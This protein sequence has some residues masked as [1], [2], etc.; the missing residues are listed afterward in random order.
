MDISNFM[1]K[2]TSANRG[3]AGVSPAQQTQSA[4]SA[5]KASGLTQST[6]RVKA[7]ATI[8]AVALVVA[9]LS[10]LFGVVMRSQAQIE[11]KNATEGAQAVLVGLSDIKAG[12]TLTEEN[13]TIVEVPAAYRSSNVLLGSD[14]SSVLGKTA[15]V[16]VSKGAQLSLGTVSG[17][18]G[19]CLAAQITPGMEG[20]TLS[21]DEESG[22]SGQ[23]QSYDLVRIFSISP[24][25]TSEVIASTICDRAKVISTGTGEGSSSSAYSA[26]TVEVSPEQADE[27]RLA[28]YSG[29]VSIALVSKEDGIDG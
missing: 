14:L 10:L 3:F 6:Q 29:S 28:Q 19:G 8:T 18:E 22:L 1:H 23:I 9:F 15:L 13:V 20:I 25:A 12:D 17:Y 26:I 21:V 24:S 4:P 5:K 7:M 16:D 11:V 27:I 2:G